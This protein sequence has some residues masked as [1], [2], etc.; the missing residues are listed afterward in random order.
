MVRDTQHNV[1]SVT[2][3]LPGA[4]GGHD[5]RKATPRLR[6]SGM[7][8]FEQSVT[9][10]VTTRRATSHA[11]AYARFSRPKVKSQA[12]CKFQRNR[13][14]AGFFGRLHGRSRAL[15]A[16]AIATCRQLAPRSATQRHVARQIAHVYVSI[17]SLPEGFWAI[18]TSQRRSLHYGRERPSRAHVFLRL[19]HIFLRR[20]TMLS[21]ATNALVM[22]AATMPSSRRCVETSTQ[23]ESLH[24]SPS[25]ITHGVTL[26]HYARR[27][28]AGELTG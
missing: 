9:R 20:A 13:S 2:K 17:N 21:I 12:K 6:A 16:G 25:S 5:A 15:R 18:E 8:R 28:T 24:A 4:C 27:H 3:H 1:A 11:R 23:Q 7:S 22:A 26:R 19:H 14:N 10:G